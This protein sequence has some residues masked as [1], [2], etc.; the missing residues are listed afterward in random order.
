MKNKTSQAQIKASRKWEEKNP[1]KTRYLS[2]R[3]AARSFVRNRATPEDMEELIKI[4]KTE[5]PNH[6]ELDS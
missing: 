3:R 5:N 1:E 2:A 6:E 4:F